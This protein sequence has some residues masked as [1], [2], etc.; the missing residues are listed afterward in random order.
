MADTFTPLLRLREQETGGNVDLWGGIK[1]T[2][3]TQLIEDAIAGV[4]DVSVTAGDVTLS[5]V[6]GGTDQQRYMFIRA[7]GTPGT[8]REIIVPATSKM[9]ILINDSDSI[10]TMLVAA[11]TGVAVAVGDNQLLMVDTTVG[12]VVA[13][14][15]SSSSGV[16]TEAVVR[17]L[18]PITNQSFGSPTVPC[19]MHKQGNRVFL[20][21]G[22]HAHNAINPANPWNLNLRF[23][24]SPDNYPGVLKAVVAHVVID[25][26]LSEVICYHT[27]LSS[28]SS[29]V[30]FVNRDGTN[31]SGTIRVVNHPV[32]I[33]WNVA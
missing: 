9:Y 6:S 15:T 2:D 21:V 11:Q 30:R 8:P 26:V 31:V 19:L 22:A 33:S 29:E 4:I 12:D 1:N 17:G 5:T 3:Q 20:T 28:G 24:F 27:G 18:A 23:L 25:T 7:T 16:V 10:V 32:T 14:Q 13:I